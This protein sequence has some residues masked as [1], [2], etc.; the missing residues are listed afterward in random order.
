MTALIGGILLAAG[1]ML[2]LIE[3][4]FSG[5]G[6]PV[7]D[8]EDDYDEGAARRRVALT[9]LRDL[10]YDRATGKLDRKD[11]ELLRAELSHDA[12]RQLEPGAEGGG[13]AD[14]PVERASRELEDEIA[15]IRRALR[16]G[17]Q[18]A[19]CE[20]LNRAGALFCARCGK[21]LQA[22]GADTRVGTGAG[23]GSG[24]GTGGDAN[25]GTGT[26]ADTGTGTAADTSSD[27]DS[28]DG[29]A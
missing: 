24:T 21:G 10:E 28:V 23:N 22:G 19:G 1:V 7:Y 18:C 2:Y 12:L 26:A 13:R 8:S 14:S 25:T 17:L 11:Y 27:A 5:R 9:A 6:A 15:Q 29:A 3:P 16:E 4:V 20:H